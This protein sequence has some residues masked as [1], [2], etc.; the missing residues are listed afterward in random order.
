MTRPFRH[1]GAGTTALEW[2]R[3]PEWAEV[4]LWNPLGADRPERVVVVAAH[5]DDES[6]GAGGVIAMIRAAGIPVTLVVATAGERSHPRSPTIT[7]T[8]LAGQRRSE[9]EQAW[10]A[11]GGDAGELTIWDLPDG[12]LAAQ[13]NE[14]TSRLVEVLGDGRATLLLAPYLEDGHSDHDA[15]GRAAQRAAYR[16][17]AILLHYPVW[18]WHH[19]DPGEVPWGR[20]RRVALAAF[21]RNAKARAVA[22]HRSQIAPLSDRPRDETLLSPSLIEHFTGPHET[23]ILGQARDDALD[24]LH[25]EHVDPW[26]TTTRWYEARKRRLLLAMLPRPRFAQA[27][28]LGCSTGTLTVDLAERCDK[29]VAVDSSPRALEAAASRTRGLPNVELRLGDLS[30]ELP[31]GNFDLVVL[32]EAGYFLSPVALDQLIA[33]ITHV[34]TADGCL[35]LAHWRHPISGWPLSGPDVHT[36]FAQARGLPPVAERYL[37]GNVEIVVHAHETTLPDPHI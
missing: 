37:E 25:S 28:D 31:E 20:L 24:D 1:D 23:F 3:R 19:A 32:S 33:G 15:L 9:A 6:L 29:L 34:L 30:A 27:L 5:P 8:A 17:G 18:L 12:S 13:E 22:C 21:D 16:T 35:V 36:R 11:L 4:P 7:A 10:A 26:G 2:V 14:A